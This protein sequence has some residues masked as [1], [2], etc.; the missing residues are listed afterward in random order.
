MYCAPYVNKQP[1]QC[2]CQCS[3][4]LC[5][6]LL[7]KGEGETIL[8]QPFHR[9]GLTSHDGL[10]VF[11]SGCS[12]F[13]SANRNG[14]ALGFSQTEPVGAKL[15]KQSCAKCSLQMVIS[16]QEASLNRCLLAVARNWTHSSLLSGSSGN[17]NRCALRR[18]ESQ[19]TTEHILVQMFTKPDT[20]ASPDVFQP[21]PQQW[22]NAMYA[23][24]E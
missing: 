10:S 21:Q 17:L 19:P 5:C 9:V 12:C 22:T 8:L 13:T 3:V 7:C 23:L 2:V 20:G 18:H 14:T 11:T 15:S 16:V 4:V 6:D 1:V 24:W